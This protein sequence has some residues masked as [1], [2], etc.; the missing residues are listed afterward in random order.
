[1]AI[2][3]HHA[4][5]HARQHERVTQR[6]GFKIIEFIF[7]SSF[8]FLGVLLDKILYE[9]SYSWQIISMYRN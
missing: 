9:T 8:E 1:M 4:E 5:I 2:G 3:I 6:Q 7:E